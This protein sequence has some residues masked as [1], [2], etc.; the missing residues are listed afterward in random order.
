MCCFWGIHPQPNH[1]LPQFIMYLPHVRNLS[2]HVWYILNKSATCKLWDFSLCYIK[3]LKIRSKKINTC[4]VQFLKFVE[5][6]APVAVYTS[7]KG[8]SAAGLTASVIRD[9]SSVSFHSC[10]LFTRCYC[11][12]KYLWINFDLCIFFVLYTMF[13]MIFTK[14]CSEN[15]I[16]KE[17]QWSWLMAVLFASMN[18]T[19]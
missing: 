3:F 10:L 4:T 19:K 11:C 16:W 18:L 5:K 13:A 17:V 8:S 9:N 7:G 2:H 12:D 14:I 1:R 15:F 6:T